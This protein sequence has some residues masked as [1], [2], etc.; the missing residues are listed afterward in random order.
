[1]DN[2]NSPADPA[3]LSFLKTI[4]KSFGEQAHLAACLETLLRHIPAGVIISEAP[5]GRI[6]YRNEQMEQQLGHPIA[7][8]ENVA[9]YAVRRGFHPDG[10]PYAPHDWP[11]ARAIT[12]GEVIAGEEIHIERL[13]GTR[14][15]LLVSASPV[16]DQLGNIIAGIVVQ[17]DITE[18]RQTT[19]ALKNCMRLE[20]A[21]R[22]EAETASAFKDKFIAM[23]SH[24]LRTPLNPIAITLC[25]MELDPRLPQDLKDDVAMLRRNI[26][27]ET[28]LIDDLLDVTSAASG[29]LILDVKP[30]RLHALLRDVVEIVGAEA[31]ERKQK[32]TLDLKAV[33]DTVDGDA[34][35]LQQ[36]FWN[37]LKNAIRFTPIGGEIFIRSLTPSQGTIAI[38]VQDGGM[39]ISAQALPRIFGA[40]EQGASHQTWHFGG[41]GLGL[42]ICE[43][44]IDL[45]GGKI[46]AACTSPGE[47]AC[48]RV[49]L[50]IGSAMEATI[51]ALPTTAREDSDSLRI[52][53]VEDHVDTLR[54]LRRLLES[55]GYLVAT[56]E[57]A[58]AAMSYVTANDFDMLLSDIGLPDASGWELVGQIK[59]LQDVPAIAISGFG[60]K[61][62]IKKSRDAGF[63]GHLTKPLDFKL[64]QSTIQ[65]AAKKG[66]TPCV[67]LAASV[68]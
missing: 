68:M 2:I 23:I 44:I 38:E 41:L 46:S 62:D 40:F 17:Q 65:Q 60:S 10:E 35:R 3:I 1:M 7:A 59:K 56:A 34:V 27:L 26:G 19:D 11:L 24:E 5:S 54:V 32:L 20:T 22:R 29:K 67:P 51:T 49:E 12:T 53:V 8:P 50:P 14:L 21:A 36:V 25:A 15:A 48:I 37:V 47:G 30:T 28:R 4:P 64:L 45:H 33:E 9:Q 52:L 61:S 55:V 66:R 13:D 58:A 63:Y 18:H 39:G 16:R 42:T 57:T 43:A 31:L 6:L